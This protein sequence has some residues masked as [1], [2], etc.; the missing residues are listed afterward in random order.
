M[1]LLL[2]TTNILTEVVQFA[3]ANEEALLAFFETPVAPS[4]VF[5]CVEEIDDEKMSS[6]FDR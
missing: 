1:P 6:F 4:V 3:S 2:F 5:E